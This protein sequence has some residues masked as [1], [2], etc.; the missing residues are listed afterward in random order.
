MHEDVVRFEQKGH[1]LD[2]ALVSKW[3]V[4]EFERELRDK[5]FVPSIDN[6]PQLTVE[7]LPSEEMF[8]YT[9]S[10]FGVKVDKDKA[11]EISGVSRGKTVMKHTQ[12][13]K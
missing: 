2:A 3:L 13:S 4:D 8:E 11:W 9:L 5:G 6:D 12:P 7:Y 1:T 10:V